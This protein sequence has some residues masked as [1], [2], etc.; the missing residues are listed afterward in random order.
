[1]VV[2]VP[3]ELQ[4]SIWILWYRVTPVWVQTEWL[5]NDGT[6]GY[7]VY[8]VK[9]TPLKVSSI[10]R[11]YQLT[12]LPQAMRQKGGGRPQLKRRGAGQCKDLRI[13]MVQL[14]SRSISSTFQRQITDIFSRLILIHEESVS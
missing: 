14:V 3:S 13:E 7:V 4:I 6:N 5:L 10:P 9:R 12:V 8:L 2:M 11:L 1:M